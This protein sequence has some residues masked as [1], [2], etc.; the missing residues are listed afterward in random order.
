M[1]LFATL[2]A[3]RRIRKANRTGQPT[4]DLSGLGLVTV[5]IEVGQLTNLQ[6][7]DLSGNKLTGLPAELGQL[8]NLQTLILDSGYAD[9]VSMALTVLG[10]LL[11]GRGDVAGARAAYQQAIDSGHPD[12]APMAM[13]NLGTL[14]EVASRFWWKSGG[15]GLPL[16]ASYAAGVTGWS[17]TS[18]SRDG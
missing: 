13:V 16:T 11:A 12:D 14:L 6:T 3:R 15:R 7:L 9:R 2:R 10:D 8:T 1:A 5:P 4:L 18:S 17:T